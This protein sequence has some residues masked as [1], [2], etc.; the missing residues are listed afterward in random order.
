MM[1]LGQVLSIQIGQ[2]ERF[3]DVRQAT[4]TGR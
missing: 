3:G 1:T 2:I 4:A